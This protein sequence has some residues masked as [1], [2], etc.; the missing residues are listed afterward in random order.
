MPRGVAEMR[1]RLAR[2]E[3]QLPSHLGT[4]LYQE[5]EE[6]IGEAKERLVPVRNHPPAGA[7][8][9][10][11]FVEP[12]DHRPGGAVRVVLGFGGPGVKY[13]ASVHENPRAGRTGGVSPSGRKYKSWAEV[14]EWKFLERPLLAAGGQLAERLGRRLR[15]LLAG[16]S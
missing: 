15:A 7:L 10:S 3:R 12:P 2:L 16:G 11:G 5:A 1:G 9:A 14:G 13:A 8:R 4:A 6:I